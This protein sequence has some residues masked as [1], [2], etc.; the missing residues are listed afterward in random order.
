MKI[1]DLSGIEQ[2][3][4]PIAQFFGIEPATALLIVG[5]IVTVAN[6]TG[7]LIPDDATGTL[8]TVRKIAKVIGLFVPNR[9]APR[10]SVNDVAKAAV[11]RQIT[12]LAQKIDARGREVLREQL[13][14][15]D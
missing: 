6:I 13:P 10:I 1:A 11:T 14:D 12:D 5:L 2:L 15:K 4:P 7:R 9:I 3:I 8:G